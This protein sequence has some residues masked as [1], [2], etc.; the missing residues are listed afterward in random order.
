MKL[1]KEMKSNSRIV[2]EDEIIFKDFSVHGANQLFSC[3]CFAETRR[4][5]ELATKTRLNVYGSKT[6]DRTVS[7]RAD[8]DLTF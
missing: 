1:K 7:Q 2:N 3:S 6:L 5:F 4:R 8:I